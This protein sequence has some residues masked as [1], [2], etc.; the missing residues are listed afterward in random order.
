M[1]PT[2]LR[3]P[4]CTTVLALPVACVR[5]SHLSSDC[6]PAPSRATWTTTTHD[7]RVE[8][9][10]TDLNEGVPLGNVEVV[11]DSGVARQRTDTL[12]RFVFDGV[13]DGRHITTT[14]AAAYVARGD[15][16][17]L[18]ERG[19]LDGSLALKLRKDVRRSCELYRP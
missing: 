2:L 9:H 16:I 17:M 19:G 13:R 11:L 10:V 8:G 18:P 7:G 14:H 1:K 6:I 12:G 3:G 15:T 4:L 5:A